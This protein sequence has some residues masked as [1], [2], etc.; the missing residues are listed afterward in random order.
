MLEQTLAENGV[1]VSHSGHVGDFP[2]GQGIVMLEPGGSV[3]SI[4]VGGSNT[5]WRPAHTEVGAGALMSEGPH[6]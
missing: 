1:D 5:A 6:M 2:S 3:S 4:V